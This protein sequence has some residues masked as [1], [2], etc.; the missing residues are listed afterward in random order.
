MGTM[1]VCSMV[2]DQRERSMFK[3]IAEMLEPGSAMVL[4]VAKEK[5]GRLCVQVRPVGEFKNAALG[6]GIT[7]TDTAEVI[8]AEFEEAMRTYGVA[9]K[10]LSEQVADRVRVLEAAAQAEKDTKATA[11]KKSVAGGKPAAKPGGASPGEVTNTQR[12]VQRVDPDQ[13]GEGGEAG[14]GASAGDEL[15]LF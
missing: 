12:A 13:A 6:Q 11:I 2:G 7:F 10:S 1:G 3:Q 9:H 5:D 4:T 8:E 15:Q 14:V